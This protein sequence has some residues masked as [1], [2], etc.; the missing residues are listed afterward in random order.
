MI[1]G[2]SPAFWVARSELQAKGVNSPARHSLRWK[3]RDV[4]PRTTFPSIPVRTIWNAVDF[5]A[6]SRTP[7]CKKLRA[8]MRKRL[9]IA[10]SDFVLV[11]LA[12]PR[13]QK[14]ME[15]LPAIVAATREEFDRRNID[16]G[17]ALL[18]AGEPSRASPTAAAAEAAIHAAI[19]EHRLGGHVHFLAPWKMWPS[20]SRLPMRC[21]ASAATRA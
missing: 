8:H 9:G 15:R 3:L 20:C 2:N 5:A 13:P 4:P 7:R 18:V 11:A 21:F 6:C 16:R 14:R 1:E 10:A 17:I 12:N 19:D